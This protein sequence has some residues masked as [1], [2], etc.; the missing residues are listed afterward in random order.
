L[1]L[2][3]TG[4]EILLNFTAVR[5]AECT[6][7]KEG[8]VMLPCREIKDFTRCADILLNG[9]VVPLTEEEKR[10]LKRYI[11]RIDDKLLANR[12]HE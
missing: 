6:L 5:W 9:L 1:I 7:R 4:L 10:L 3:E 2:S 8:A 12:R 11:E